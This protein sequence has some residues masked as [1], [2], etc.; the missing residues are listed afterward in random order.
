[1]MQKEK[2]D[3]KKLQ[4]GYEVMLENYNSGLNDFYKEATQA[5]I[6]E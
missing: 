4:Q 6:E 3:F 2:A 5:P 1:M